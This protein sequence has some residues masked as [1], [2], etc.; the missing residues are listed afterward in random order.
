MSH[1]VFVSSTCWDLIDLRAEIEA[2]LRDAGLT[3]V[4]SDIPTTDFEVLA[5]AN[6]I[7]SCLAN[8]QSSDFV[9]VVLSR[10]YGPS[11]RKAGPGFPDIS[12]THAEYNEAKE[13]N[14][15]ISMYVRD[16]LM[17]DYQFHRD[18][19]SSPRLRWVGKEEDWPLFDL[20]DQHKK[21]TA[22]EGSSNWFWTFRHSVDLK[23][24]I[25]RDLR[26]PIGRAVIEELVRQGRTPLVRVRMQDDSFRMEDD[27]RLFIHAFIH[28]FSPHRAMDVEVHI[29]GVGPTTLAETVPLLTEDDEVDFRVWLPAP[30]RVCEECRAELL[31]SCRYTTLNGHVLSD[32]TK[33]TLSWGPHSLGPTA[34]KQNRKAEMH[35]DS[36]VYHH[37][38]AIPIRVEV[39][40]PDGNEPQ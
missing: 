1:R 21:L 20:I 37:A 16:K 38:S 10:R 4:M 34:W 22:D 19:P 11:L 7:E 24:M 2:D 18:N 3:P 25:R 5:D 31:V 8:V 29:S 40:D 26:A 30:K 13:A 36:K 12:A 23:E 17:A 27:G 6:S 39:T 15:P 32:Q 35:Y 14:K 33:V 9:L 28:N